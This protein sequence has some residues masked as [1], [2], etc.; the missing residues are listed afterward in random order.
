LVADAVQREMR[1]WENELRDRGLA[2][3]AGE[4]VA[5][6]FTSSWVERSGMSTRSQEL[7]REWALNVFVWK[8]GPITWLMN[9]S[10]LK[11]GRGER[12]PSTELQ[13]EKKNNACRVRIAFLFVYSCTFPS[14]EFD[15]TNP[16]VQHEDVT[17]FFFFQET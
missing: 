13:E 8:F 16:A 12:V 7:E 5:R 15:N 2:G 1:P 11:K 9:T 17:S 3:C 4:G 10:I 14:S 6:R